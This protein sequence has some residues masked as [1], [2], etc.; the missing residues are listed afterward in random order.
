VILGTVFLLIALYALATAVVPRWRRAAL[1]RGFSGARCGPLTSLGLACL[2][3]AGGLSPWL[4]V[5]A[6]QLD[7]AWLFIPAA[8]GF[9]LIFADAFLDV[10]RGRAGQSRTPTS[11]GEDGA[12]LNAGPPHE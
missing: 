4:R 8:L 7:P 2:F 1:P 12:T 5:V 6:P 3:G 10:R 9:V 11:S